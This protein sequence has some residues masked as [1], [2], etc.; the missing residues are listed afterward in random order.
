MS[1][2]FSIGEEREQNDMKT[3]I[4]DAGKSAYQKSNSARLA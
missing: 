1:S 4:Y 2:M 3:G